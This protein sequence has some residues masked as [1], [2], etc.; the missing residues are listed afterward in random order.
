MN[1]HLFS[2]A[3]WII[4]F[5]FST[6]I[7]YAQSFEGWITYK[8]EAL[9]PN[10]EIISDSLFQEIMKEQFGDRGYMVQKY[11]YK[12]DNYISEVDAGKQIGYQGYNIKD[13]LIYAWQ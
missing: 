9:N 6:T 12:G 1:K 8:L 3:F 7:S 4:I 13:K 5:S 10:S 2:R 11:F